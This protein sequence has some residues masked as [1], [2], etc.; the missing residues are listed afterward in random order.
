MIEKIKTF[1]AN[2]QKKFICFLIVLFAVAFYLCWQASLVLL[3]LIGWFSLPKNQD[4]S[5]QELTR[6]TIKTQ[7]DFVEATKET[8]IKRAIEKEH[9]AQKKNGIGAWIDT[10]DRDSES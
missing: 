9:K 8:T 5:E 10:T 7:R 4:Q 6:Q 2:H 3:P 1:A